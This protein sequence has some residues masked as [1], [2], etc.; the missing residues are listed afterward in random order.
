MHDLRGDARRACDAHRER[1]FA[2]PA[3]VAA[4]F[5]LVAVAIAVAALVSTVVGL[6]V[7]ERLAV[8]A[9]ALVAASLVA[10]RTALS[11][12]AGLALLVIRPYAAGER[13]RLHS[14]ADG[15]HIEAVIVHIGAVNTTLATDSGLLVVANA[16]LLKDG[17]EPTCTEK[18]MQA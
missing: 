14:P 4:P 7:G 18:S 2:S 12:F 13:V 16:R 17:P 1:A 15:G 3:P 9:G 10:H 6:P 8:V 11:L 5:A